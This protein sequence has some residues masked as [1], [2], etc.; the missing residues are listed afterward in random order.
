MSNDS[1][2]NAPENQND[3]AQQQHNDGIISGN[4]KPVENVGT[5]HGGLDFRSPG[6]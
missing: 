1:S 5:V 3:N 4:Q 6:K 2:N